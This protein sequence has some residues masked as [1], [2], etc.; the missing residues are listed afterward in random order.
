[1]GAWGSCSG[2]SWMESSIRKIVIAASAAN[3]KLFTWHK[4]NH[5][6]FKNYWWNI[7][8]SYVKN[9]VKIYS[10]WT[11]SFN[12]Q[13]WCRKIILSNLRHGGLDDAVLDGVAQGTICQIQTRVMTLL[14]AG[15]WRLGVCRAQLSKKLGRIL[16]RVESELL[17]D[18]LEGVG[19]LD[20]R[21]PN[22]KS[23]FW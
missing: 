6:Q 1:M 18:H 9:N 8:Q 23:R 2:L 10:K 14:V 13:L 11:T 17:G 5:E 21:Q 16:C 15:F 12:W 7:I 20:H 4:K 22:T 3:L 19:E